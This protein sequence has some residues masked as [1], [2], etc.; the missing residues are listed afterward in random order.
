MSYYLPEN[1]NMNCGIYR[2]VNRSNGKFY[3]GSSARLKDRK[4]THFAQLRKNR[5]ANS[6]LQ[7]AWNVEPE[8]SVFEF[9]AFIFC[10]KEDLISM[11]QSCIDIMK[12]SYNLSAVAG[13]IEMTEL[14]RKKMSDKKKGKPSPRLGVKLSFEQI[15]KT[16]SKLRGRP[17][18]KKGTVTGIAPW[19]KGIN[20]SEETKCK[21][22]NATRLLWKNEEYCAAQKEARKRTAKEKW[23]DPEYR[24]QQIARAKARWH[25]STYRQI[26][27]YNSWHIS[28]AMYQ[29]YYG[30]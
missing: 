27:M 24:A 14:V 9:N 25:D 5:H 1:T 20:Q 7:N 2:I 15:E 17:S 21:L 30:A 4:A 28:N 16:A 8:K 26:M 12:P 19:N 13:K 6:Y 23:K 22:K 10:R 18:P 29:R 11:E 3:I